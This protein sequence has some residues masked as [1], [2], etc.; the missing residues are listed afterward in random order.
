MSVQE[1]YLF[2]LH[3]F[4]LVPNVEILMLYMIPF[5]TRQVIP[6]FVIKQFQSNDD[7][8]LSYTE[9]YTTIRN[10]KKNYSE[11]VKIQQKMSFY[12][13]LL[14]L[15]PLYYMELLQ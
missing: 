6:Y 14:I 5:K 2:V 8:P 1:L 7:M 12:F 3:Y 4:S 15:A 9:L 13:F 11:Y 10:H